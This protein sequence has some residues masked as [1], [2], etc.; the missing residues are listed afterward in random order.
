MPE[1][2]SAR[3]MAAPTWREIVPRK[4]TSRSVN[5]SS[6]A[7]RVAYSSPHMPP[8]NMIG[9]ATADSFPS[10]RS[11]STSA[12]WVPGSPSALRCGAW[13]SNISTT[14]GKSASG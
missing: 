2:S 10:D 6:P 9:T 4:R 3:P 1:N 5:G 13:C 14:R 8:A 11:S 12:G 7:H